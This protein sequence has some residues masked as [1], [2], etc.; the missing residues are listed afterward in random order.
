MQVQME[1]CLI[2]LGV[3]GSLAPWIARCERIFV[4]AGLRPE[5]HAWGT[6]VEGDW[7]TVMACVRRC[8]VELHAAGAPRLHSA[9]KLGTRIDKPQ[10][11]A[12]KV[13]AVRALDGRDLGR[14]D[15]QAGEGQDPA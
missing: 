10:A 5:L 7:D 1:L 14:Q 15:G 8:H 12:D 3:E 2:P 9:I 4:D 13:R 6:N 11:L